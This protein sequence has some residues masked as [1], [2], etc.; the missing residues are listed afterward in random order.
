MHENSMVSWESEN[1]VLYLKVLKLYKLTCR[2]F[3]ALVIS[4]ILLW[5]QYS[6]VC[7]LKNIHKQSTE[8]T[9]NPLHLDDCTKLHLPYYEFKAVSKLNETNITHMIQ[10]ISFIFLRR[11]VL[12][13]YSSDQSGLWTQVAVSSLVPC[14]KMLQWLSSVILLDN[15]PGL[16]ID[17]LINPNV[18]N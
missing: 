12:E 10:I 1:A 7:S 5:H 6:V 14:T 18:L 8:K 13:L 2:L 17:N 16:G 15:L 9:L 11:D 4:Y 3:Y